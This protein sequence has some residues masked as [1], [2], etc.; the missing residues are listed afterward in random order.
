MMVLQDFHQSQFT[1]ENDNML[2][3]L[4]SLHHEYNHLERITYF[5]RKYGNFLYCSLGEAN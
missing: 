3:S 2:L 4:H 1:G 5:L